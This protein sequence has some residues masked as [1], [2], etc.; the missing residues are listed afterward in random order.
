MFRKFDAGKM[1]AIL[2]VLVEDLLDLGVTKEV[3]ETFVGEL[4]STFKIKDLGDASYCM[5]CNITRDRAKK[6]LKFYQHLYAR[7]I[8]ERFGIDRTAMVPAT[9]GVKPLSK[10]H[11][12]KTRRSRKK[13]RRL[14]RSSGGTSVDIDDDAARYLECGLHRG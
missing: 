6:E 2:V 11:G 13:R 4:R 14:P 12:P 10:N 9:A 7:T 5:G 1:E 8:T 3:M